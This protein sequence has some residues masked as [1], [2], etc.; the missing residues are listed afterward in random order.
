[1]TNA[2]DGTAEPVLEDLP[3]DDLRDRAFDVAE[4]RRDVRFF[5]DL[6]GHLPAVSAVAG[7]GGGL[8]DIGASIE[9]AVHGTRELMGEESIGELEP[10]F[11]ARFATYI[12]EHGEK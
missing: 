8:G 5:L 11:R 3:W 10:L 12:R 9:S 7:E 1:M 4:R 2:A 6:V